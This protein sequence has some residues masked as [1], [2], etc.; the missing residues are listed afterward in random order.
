MSP[1]SSPTAHLTPPTAAAG[2]A[3]APSADPSAHALAA[4]WA[5]AGLPAEA[6]AHI[7]VPGNHPVLPSSFAVATAAQAS[8]GAAALAA[9]E[10]WQLRTG[11]RQAV[12]VDRAHATLECSS[13]LSIGGRVPELWDKLSGLYACGEAIGRPGWVRIHANFAHHR[14]GA[15]QLLGLP[16]GPDT[17]RDAV[18]QALRGWAADSFEQAAAD[19]GLVVAAARSFAQWDAHPQALALAT[20]PLVAITPIGAAGSPPATWPALPWPA[21]A[22]GQRPLAGLRVLDL[23]RILAGPVAG[24][25][26]AAYGAEV[27]MVNGPHLPNI[28]AIASLSRGKRSS[29]IDLRNDAGRA[30]LG[31]LVQG[32]DVFLQ[33]YHPGALASRGFGAEALATC[34]P[35]IVVASLSAYGQSAPPGPWA[36]RRGFDSLVQTATGFNLAEAEAAGSPTPKALPMQILDYA[37]GHLL[38]FGIQAALWRR[39]TQ[40]GSWQVQVSLA[41]VGLWLR[42]L[43]RVPDG[44]LAHK[45]DI[46]PLLEDSP[47]GFG[48]T[49]AARQMATLRTVRHAAQFSLTPA[50]FD[51]PSMPP[52]HDAP[53]WLGAAA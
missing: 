15:L 21:L 43:G 45:P 1:S 18:A 10:L 19:A 14:D 31:A 37:A 42:S 53:V 23:T 39:A 46:E 8:L 27:L 24:R 5:A 33:G 17:P 26:L 28:E 6:L 32:A 47:C 22:P 7:D 51:R 12:Q 16:A 49:E 41:G 20:Q 11:Q 34:R 2:L 29:L 3:P 13:W 50:G 35:G 44:L 52:G 25:C 36:G 38:A 48:G 4:L 30:Q 9:A 40:G